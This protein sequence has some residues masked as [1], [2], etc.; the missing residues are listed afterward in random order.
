MPA[1]PALLI[2]EDE[3][4][5]GR[6]LQDALDGMVD[7]HL[8]AALGSA[9]DAAKTAGF[10]A[11]IVDCQLADG[12]ALARLPE[13]RLH[14]G[15]QAHVWMTSAEWQEDKR[16]AYLA[17]GAAA[18]WSKPIAAATLRQNVATG[19]AL[20][21][22]T[23]GLWNDDAALTRLGGKLEQVEA[24]R[25]MLLTELPTQL[26]RILQARDRGDLASIQAELHRLR[27]ACG[28]CGA[29]RLGAAIAVWSDRRDHTSLDSVLG[30]AQH[31]LAT[32]RLAV[33]D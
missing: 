10:E 15:H 25:Q 7:C 24:L 16:Q 18:C 29:D 9:I 27:A 11:A 32:R 13:L 3:P 26:Q 31:L 33:A 2:V 20:A 5:S 1:L 8:H 17:A 4:V 30:T 23:T 28:F 6:F 21:G 19:L 12:D 14:L 22:E